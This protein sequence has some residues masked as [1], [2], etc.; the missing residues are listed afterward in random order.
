MNAY[1]T[2]VSSLF[3][4]LYV[5]L[6]YLNCHYHELFQRSKIFSSFALYWDYAGL[7]EGNVSDLLEAIA[8]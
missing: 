4:S 2:L 8:L 7:L 1:K 3:S 5:C 6:F